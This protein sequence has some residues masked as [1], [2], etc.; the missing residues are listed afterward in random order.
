MITKKIRIHEA[1]N[2]WLE[3]HV[4]HINDQNRGKPNQI[5]LNSDSI[6]IEAIIDYLQR[7]YESDLSKGRHI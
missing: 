6:I 7:N 1:I 2:N 4:K 3:K 5:M